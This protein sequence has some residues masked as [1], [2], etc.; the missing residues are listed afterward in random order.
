MPKW[1]RADLP[2]MDGRTVVITGAGS[3]IGLIA[4]RELAG[5]GA[6]TATNYFGPFVLT[7]LLADRITDRVV[8]VTSQLHRLAR[9]DLADLDW[10]TRTLY[11][12]TED[13]P[14]NAYVGPDGL[15]SVKGHPVVRRPGKRGRDAEKARQLWDATA[16]LTGVSAVPAA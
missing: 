1:T 5:V 4:A 13:V 6:T 3:G 2:R 10:R 12:A 7:N 9:L 11:A 16:V 15:G 8:S 14:G